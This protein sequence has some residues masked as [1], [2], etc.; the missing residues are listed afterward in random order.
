MPVE[1]TVQLGP[2]ALRAPGTFAV[3]QTDFGVKPCSGGPGGSVKVADR[4]T[5]AVDA[6]SVR[7][8]VH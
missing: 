3:K 6:V 2:D 8:P 4:V 7:E 5:F 1:A